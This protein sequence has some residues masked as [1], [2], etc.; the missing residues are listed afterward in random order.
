MSPNS[1]SNRL[2]PR[3]RRLGSFFALAAIGAT[4]LGCLEP[5]E[6]VVVSVTVTPADVQLAS[7]GDTGAT[8][9]ITVVEPG[10]RI[11]F[12]RYG[13]VWIMEPDGSNVMNLTDSP[14]YD[15]ISWEQSPWSPDGSRITF[16]SV[17]EQTGRPGRTLAHA[18]RRQRSVYA[19]PRLRSEIRLVT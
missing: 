10:E 2:P 7:I 8:A 5:F 3:L 9:L 13:D 6:P 12:E 14:S 11:V 18:G 15:A 4:L 1:E 16:I 17:P 19:L